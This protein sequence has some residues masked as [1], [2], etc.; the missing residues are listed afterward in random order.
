VTQGVTGPRDPLEGP[1]DR[2]AH[3][4]EQ[5]ADEIEGR[6]LEDRADIGERRA[7]DEHPRVQEHDREVGETEGEPAA[8][9]CVP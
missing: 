5:R 2:A 8:A 4:D 3:N 6:E 1:T 7:A 9:E